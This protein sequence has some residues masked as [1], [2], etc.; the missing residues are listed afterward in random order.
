MALIKD[1]M[2]GF[3]ED[4][5]G[6]EVPEVNTNLKKFR[7]WNIRA[8]N[9]KHESFQSVLFQIVDIDIRFDS[10]SALFD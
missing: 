7:L 1:I 10:I 3:L 2:F 5:H 9:E 4:V 6:E 8:L